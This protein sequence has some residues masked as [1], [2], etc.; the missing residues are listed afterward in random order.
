MNISTLR[1]EGPDSIR[2]AVLADG[3]GDYQLGPVTYK[4]INM[5]TPDTVLWDHIRIRVLG[6]VTQHKSFFRVSDK[7]S[8]FDSYIHADVMFGG[9]AAVCY[10]TPPDLIPSSHR[11]GGTAFWHHKE[12]C[13]D[14][15]RADWSPEQA[16]KVIADWGDQSKFH[17]ARVMQMNYGT[18]ILYP[19]RM[20]HSPYPFFGFGDKP[21]N[22]RMI[23]AA[24]FD[25]E[26]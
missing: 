18:M 6:T 20:F 10:L 21:E 24:F 25:I 15:M 16:Q 4:G 13:S 26:L 17:K 8:T 1:I 22:S 5:H 14:G 7:G 3:F 12:T 9:W 23:W 19:S 11:Y 2:K